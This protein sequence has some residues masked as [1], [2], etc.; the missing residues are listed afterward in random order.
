LAY[1]CGKGTVWSVFDIFSV[2]YKIL[3]EAS[4][5]CV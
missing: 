2:G 5:F 1:E 4:S 3:I